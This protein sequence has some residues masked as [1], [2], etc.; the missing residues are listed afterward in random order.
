MNDG[1]D[2]RRPRN[3][4]RHRL[5]MLFGG[6]LIS[7]AA[8]SDATSPRVDADQD[9]FYADED[10]DDT[11][12]SVYPDAPD[13][14]YD[15]VDSDCAGNDDFDA[16]GDGVRSPAGGG[17]DC[18]DSDPLISPLEQ[19]IWYD[20]VDQDC[21]EDNDYDVDVDGFESAAHGGDDCDDADPSIWPGATEI[22]YDGIDSEC[23]ESSDFDADGDG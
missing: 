12:A 4:G 1:A 14:W 19:E 7:C 20:G 6:C 17:S 9:C 21:R 8:E 10:C 16:D 11:N 22:W 23:D 5:L 2:G 18:D 13:V 15:G 3:P